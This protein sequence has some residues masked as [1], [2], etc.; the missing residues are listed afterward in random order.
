[1]ATKDGRLLIS[2]TRPQLVPKAD[3]YVYWDEFGNLQTID[4]ADLGQVINRS[5]DPGKKE[6]QGTCPAFVRAPGFLIPVVGPVFRPISGSFRFVFAAP[7]GHQP[8][9]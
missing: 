1:M 6:R 3:L 4:R 5:A 8:C 9:L 7:P 2:T